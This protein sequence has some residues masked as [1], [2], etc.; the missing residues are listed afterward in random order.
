VKTVLLMRHAKAGE[1]LHSQ[2][3]FDR[4]LT[5]EGHE[6]AAETAHL[7]KRLGVRIDVVLASAAARTR[8][9]ADAVRE[10][11]C[12]E[13]RLE[14]M[15]SLYHAPAESYAHA[16]RRLTLE[17]DSTVLI[18]GHNP[19]IADL[20]C[21][22]SDESLSVSTATVAIFESPADVWTRFRRS[23]G[24]SLSLSCL[25][26]NARIVRSTPSFSETG[27]PRTRD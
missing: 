3:D 12:P 21:R 9:T 16:A 24:D 7:L 1:G 19:G 8:Q 2:R 10:I 20:I 13:A 14:L 22:W 17:T 15:D 4:E 11:A 27:D 26:Q 6:T 23:H 5:S 18:V 25:I